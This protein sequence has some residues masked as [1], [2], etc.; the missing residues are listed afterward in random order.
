MAKKRKASE[1]VAEPAAAAVAEAP[2]ASSSGVVGD[3]SAVVRKTAHKKKKVMVLCSRGVTNTEMEMVEDL[4]KIMPHGKKD[5][6]FEKREALSSISEVASLAG[7]RLCLYFESRKRKDLYLWAADASGGPSVKF[8]VDKIK[9]MGDTRLTGNCLKGSRPMLSFDASFADR[10]HLQLM[11]ELFTTIF[12]IPKGH[13][14][15]KPF[16]DHVMSF[17]AIGGK[18]VIRHYQVVPPLHDKKKE[19]QSLVEIGPRLTLVPIRI[20]GG[21]FGGE[22]IF[23]NDKYVSPNDERAERRQRSASRTRGQVAQKSKR[24]QRIN[25]RGAADMP[26]DVLEDYLDE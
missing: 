1:A 17:T 18:I 13:P 8:L 10:P 14:G 4:L 21:A 12:S 23:A 16:H 19:E 9:P 5:F 2:A 15:S 26:A 11:R 3:Y 24:R 25:V 6:K 22:T 7:C 20:F